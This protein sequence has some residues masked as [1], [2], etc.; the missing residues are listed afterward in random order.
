MNLKK[1]L[2]TF[3]AVAVSAVSFAYT[4]HK[5][6][7]PLTQIMQQMTE[8]QEELNK[9][10]DEYLLD[11]VKNLA[12]FALKTAGSGQELTEQQETQ[13]NEILAQLDQT[14]DA[15]AAP[16]LEKVNLDKV[17]AQYVPMMK[18]LNEAEEVEPLTEESFKELLKAFYLMMALD[19]FTQTQQISEEQTEILFTM[20]FPN[21]EE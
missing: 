20:I 16:A 10:F 6:D 8:Q 5:P 3:T 11:P 12:D 9:S 2:L 1:Y 13:L 14:L 15:L 19:H 7:D 18:W 21:E 4:L 17:N